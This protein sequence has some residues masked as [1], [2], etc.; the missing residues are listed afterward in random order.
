MGEKGTEVK[1]GLRRAGLWLLGFAWLGLV[2]AGMAIAFTPSPHSPAVG[3]VL[4]A[5]AAAIALVT[6]D[7]WVK[8]FPGLLAYGI[9]GSVLEL[10]DGHAVGLPQAPVSRP[11]AV[12]SLLFCA[13]GAAISVTFA[14]RKLHATDRVALFAFVFCFFWQAADPKIMR[15]ALGTGLGL[16]LF[17]WLYDHFRHR[18]S[19]GS[20]SASHVT[21]L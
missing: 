9:L 19:N 13:V 2:F 12:I 6:M 14:R 17:A 7:R 1:Q 3:W 4:L 5:V 11:D 10:S 20:R 18:R 16:L 21:A 8:I 15:I